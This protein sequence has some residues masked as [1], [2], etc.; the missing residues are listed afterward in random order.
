RLLQLAGIG[1]EDIVLEIGCVTG[2]S[3]AVISCLAGSVIALESD[4]V[5]AAQASANL[6]RLGYDNAVVVE[7]PLVEGHAA[8]A[9]YDFI[10][11]NG[12]VEEVPEALFAQLRDGGR[13]LAIVGTGNTGTATMWTSAGETRSS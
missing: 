1:A 8:E 2:Y 12:A 7:G 3:T 6:S 10:L 13:L 4:P 9:P 5:L 11:L